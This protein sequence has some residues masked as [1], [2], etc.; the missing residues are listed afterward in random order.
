MIYQIEKGTLE[1]R[2]IPWII[3]DIN[4]K[5]LT[6]M[7]SLKRDHIRKFIFFERGKI[8]FVQ[9]SS[10]D[11]QLA[12][13][14]LNGGVIDDQQFGRLQDIVRESGWKSPEI[15]ENLQISDDTLEWWLRTLIRSVILSVFVWDKG[16]YRFFHGKKAPKSC[17]IVQMDPIQ[18]T[19]ASL[20]RIS[21]P[22]V[23]ISWVKDLD[24]VPKTDYEFLA[25]HTK[26][27]TLTPQEGFFMSRIDGQLSFRQILSMSSQTRL[28]M[29]QF[30]IACIITG[31]IT[32]GER[33]PIIKPARKKIQTPEKPPQQ[34]EKQGKPTVKK[35]TIDAHSKVDA[36]ADAD[37]DDSIELTAEELEELKALGDQ[38]ALPDTDIKFSAK[39]AENESIGL[40]SKIS[41]LRDGEFIETEFED[42]IDISQLKQLDLQSGSPGT[43]SGISIFID[44]KEVDAEDSLIG[45]ETIAEIFATDDAEEQWNRWITID[46]D[47][48]E[49]YTNEWKS[50]WKTWEEQQREIARLQER[51]NQ[52]QLEIEKC[53]NAEQLKRL[54]EQ[55]NQ[56]DRYFEKVLALKKKE[57]LNAQR[58]ANLQN[59]YEILTVQ[60]DASTEEIKEKYFFWLNEF[61][62]DARYLKE[63]EAMQPTLESLV[64][65]LHQAYEVLSDEKK[66][67]EYDKALEQQRRASERIAMKKKALAR[68]HLMSCREALK[69]NDIMLAVRFLRGSMSLDPRNPLYYQ[70]M[71]DIISRD[72][73]YWSEAL[74]YYHRA[75]SLNPQS[76]SLLIKVAQLAH[77]LNQP[78]FAR[79][80]L[81]QAL[82]MD[83]GNT[84]ARKFLEKIAS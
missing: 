80:V 30:F 83:P 25:Q 24:V 69:K 48:A 21:D 79:K 71:A 32:V 58:R 29:L 57:I 27:L 60:P 61:Q 52:L 15:K 6:G 84:S 53:K 9:S 20:R 10:P 38:V 65:K 55:F 82:E 12:A 8:V 59:Y 4:N 66:R 5:S 49:D 42:S 37:T 3:R 50:S 67:A 26:E 16:D 75:Y 28:E 63:F 68:D 70:E 54:S 64:T 23:L 33:T 43:K 36:A 17:R 18:I 62:P 44:G 72:K 51:R 74:L 41:Y 19:F 14:M 47:T 11:E 1:G 39:K 46:V 81:Q 73:K 77:R 45:T 56:S 22:R 35:E 2:L 31:L 76:S 78:N 7:L 13:L 34:P 40:D